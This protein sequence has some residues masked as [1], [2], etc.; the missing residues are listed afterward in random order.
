MTEW[1]D[2]ILKAAGVTDP[3][4]M[5]DAELLAIPGVGITGLQAIRRDRSAQRL[6]LAGMALAAGN[7][8]R[9]AVQLADAVL[10]ELVQ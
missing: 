9:D 6:W 1:I 2:N 8:P 10:K 4:K 3:G 7:G 5:T